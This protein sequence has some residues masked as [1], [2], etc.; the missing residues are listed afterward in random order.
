MKKIVLS[1]FD[2][3][4]I[5]GLDASYMSYNLNNF[6]IIKITLDVYCANNSGY[7]IYAINLKRV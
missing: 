7:T 1:P 3:S 2:G 4:F 6:R 5:S